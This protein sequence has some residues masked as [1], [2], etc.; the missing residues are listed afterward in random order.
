MALAAAAGASALGR[1]L[2]RSRPPPLARR[3][4]PRGPPGRRRAGLA[5]Q[6]PEINLLQVVQ[7]QLTAQATGGAGGWSGGWH[8]PLEGVW[9]R[10]GPSKVGSLLPRAVQ[11]LLGAEPGEPGGA[12][13]A[14]G[15]DGAA[16]AA[17]TTGIGYIDRWGPP[18]GPL[19]LGAICVEFVGLWLRALY[20]MSLFTPVLLLAPGAVWYGYRRESWLR[21]LR[22]TLERAG[23]AFIKWGQWAATRPDMFPRD[24]CKELAVMHS[25]A[26]EHSWQ[27][28][29][30]SIRAA[31]GRDPED[32]FD[33]FEAKPVA[34]GSI[35]QI[36]KASL[37]AAA[38]RTCGKSPGT[39]VAVKVKHPGVNQAI[40]RDFAILLGVVDVL[41]SLSPPG[42]LR[43]VEESVRQFRGPL[44]EQT[45]LERE[46]YHLHHFIRN[47]RD[48]PTVSFPEPLY[49]FVTKDVLTETFEPGVSV[50]NFV[51]TE[52]PF[53]EELA[54][55]GCSSFMHMLLRDNLIHADL[56]PGNVLVRLQE[57]SWLSKLGAIF[58]GRATSRPV[59]NVVLLDVGMAAEVEPQDQISLS[60]L[61][62][63]VV[64]LDGFG[65]AN[66]TLRLQD[67]QPT[68][69][70]QPFREDVEELFKTFRDYKEKYNSLPEP[71]ECMQE[72]L[73][74]VRQHKVSIKS[75]MSIVVATSFV[76][77]GW[78]SKMDPGLNMVRIMGDYIR[79]FFPERDP[80]K[81]FDLGR[82][83][84]R[85]EGA[86]AA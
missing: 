58:Q 19:S 85:V 34:S 65:V 30:R 14:G 38:A 31:F 72:L 18:E 66:A 13:G 86:I 79:P 27:H 80:A 6:V 12:R 63:G 41:V 40:C 24:V 74:V 48:L 51:N 25:D 78:A 36:H 33:S 32:I 7:K 60:H 64:D 54:Q 44:F 70:P 61:F 59:C 2:L 84:L 11:G 76:L 46:A 43:T 8:S 29:R 62:L 49:P 69:Q 15:G 52:H 53:Q 57:P 68:D 28:T 23:P 39:A 47:F 83:L 55:L 4:P 21:L 82:E 16:A 35:A 56:H 20:L 67:G 26:P 42:D 77:E 37:S 75:E 50:Q 22:H 9:T 45:D 17:R 5:T 73:E 1:A 81:Q 10:L 71:S 3:P